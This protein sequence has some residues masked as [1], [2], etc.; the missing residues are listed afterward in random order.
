MNILVSVWLHTTN[1]T[2]G[3][4]VFCFG[5]KNIGLGKLVRFFGLLFDLFVRGDLLFLILVYRN[6]WR[7]LRNMMRSVEKP[8]NSFGISVDHWSFKQKK[9]TEREINK[10]EIRLSCTVFISVVKVFGLR[11]FCCLAILFLLFW[12]F[13]FRN[14]STKF[15]YSKGFGTFLKISGYLCLI[16]MK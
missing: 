10:N 6:K 16:C 3:Y 12:C 4:C 11:P 7:F 8:E 1:E 9:S 13:A 15:T 2:K 5:E 14:H